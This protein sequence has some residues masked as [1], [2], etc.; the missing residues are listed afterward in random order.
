VLVGIPARGGGTQRLTRLIG[1]ARA[2]EFLLAC[3]QWR[4]EQAKQ[5]GLITDHLP[6]ATS[7]QLRSD[8]PLDSRAPSLPRPGPQYFESANDAL[9]RCT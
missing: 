8:R 9:R 5:A 6:K 4:P 1:K 2:L 3:D 7:V